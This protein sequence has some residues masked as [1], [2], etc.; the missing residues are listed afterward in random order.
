TIFLFLNIYVSGDYAYVAS[1]I[2]GLAVIDISDPTHPGTPVYE[3]TTGEAF[4]V[5]VSGDYAYV[6][7]I[8]SGLAVIDISDPTNPGTPVYED[9]TGDA[10]DVYVSGNYAYVADDISGLA[11]IDIS[12]M[13]DST[14]PFG[15]SFLIFIGFS[16]IC[17]IFIKKRQ[18]VR[19]SR[20]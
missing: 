5:Y 15:N 7:D 16:V 13:E 8:S 6:A 14:I 20:K 18:I 9:T 11:V 3:D 10:R 19:K 1:S 12:D 2:Y 17:L 4:E